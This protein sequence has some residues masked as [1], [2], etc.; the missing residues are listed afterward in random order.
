MR[1]AVPVTA[2]LITAGLA[3]TVIR[4]HRQHRTALAQAHTAGYLLAIQHVRLGLLKPPKG[5]TQQ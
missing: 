4:L 2:A 3:T 5:S 1:T